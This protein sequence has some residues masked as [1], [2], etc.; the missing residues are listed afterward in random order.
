MKNKVKPEKV[1]P[2]KPIPTDYKILQELKG[3]YDI[4]KESRDMLDKIWRQ[5][6]P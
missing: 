1:K 3:I 6:Q 2:P 5:Q 4:L